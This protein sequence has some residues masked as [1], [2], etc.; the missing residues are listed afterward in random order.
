M[1]CQV[2]Q[3]VSSCVKMSQKERERLSWGLYQ[4]Y[5]G[6]LPLTIIHILRQTT[7]KILFWRQTITQLIP[8]QEAL[9]QKLGVQNDRLG[10][11]ISVDTIKKNHNIHS[12]GF[13]QNILRDF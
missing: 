11:E 13:L 3:V 2:F 4:T 9:D 8:F 7:K 12:D 10:H 6:S 1:F 5:T